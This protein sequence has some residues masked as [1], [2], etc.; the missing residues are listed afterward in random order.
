MLKILAAVAKM[1]SVDPR[2]NLHAN[3]A[4][5]VSNAWYENGSVPRTSW[6]KEVVYRGLGLTIDEYGK[7]NTKLMEILKNDELYLQ[8]GGGQ[9]KIIL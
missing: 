4:E 2:H 8:K 6:S 3:G 9:E 1:N 7:A 5:P